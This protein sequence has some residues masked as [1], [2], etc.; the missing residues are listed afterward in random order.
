M[1]TWSLGE[2]ETSANNGLVGPDVCFHTRVDSC[3][4]L[5]LSKAKSHGYYCCHGGCR[6]LDTVRVGNI[7]PPLGNISEEVL[8]RTKQ[9][10]PCISS[11]RFHAGSLSCKTNQVFTNG[12]LNN[13]WNSDQRMKCYVSFRR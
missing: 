2:R 5:V 13:G 4:G 12:C 11:N 8:V 1:G 3:G 6:S 7:S 9:Y 10:I